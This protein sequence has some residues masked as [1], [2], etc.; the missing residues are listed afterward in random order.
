MPER[1]TNR[2]L[3][4]NLYPQSGLFYETMR[5]AGFS[6]QEVDTV[7]EWTG[8]SLNSESMKN[9]RNLPVDFYSFIHKSIPNSQTRIEVLVETFSTS[10]S[11]LMPARADRMHILLQDL[12]KKSKSEPK[13]KEY[14]ATACKVMVPKE[15]GRMFSNGGIRM[16]FQALRDDDI[17]K[18]FANSTN[19]LVDFIVLVR[20][21]EISLNYYEEMMDTIH[22]GK[23]KKEFLKG[24]NTSFFWKLEDHKMKSG[25]AGLLANESR[26]KFANEIIRQKPENWKEKLVLFPKTVRTFGLSIVDNKTLQKSVFEDYEK[27]IAKARK[28]RLEEVKEKAQELSPDKRS[29]IST[30]LI[31]NLDSQSLLKYKSELQKKIPSYEVLDSAEL[32]RIKRREDPRHPLNKLGIARTVGFEIEFM[33]DSITDEMESTGLFEAL[34]YAGFKPGGGGAE[35]YEISPGPFYDPL[36][37]TSVFE[38]Y[39][40]AGILRIDSYD[41]FT[42]HFNVS[43]LGSDLVPLIRG[44]YL[45]GA[46][47]YS[48]D[49]FKDSQVRIG[50]KNH[51]LGQYIECKSFSV[52]TRSGFIW[53]MKAASYLSWALCAYDRKH[54]EWGEVKV[55]KWTEELSNIWHEYVSTLGEGLNSV[56]M[57]GYLY[58][59]RHLE[60]ARN[61]REQLNLIYPTKDSRYKNIDNVGNDSPFIFAVSTA[62]KKWPN[63]A[64]F[65]TE[66]A[67]NAVSK[68]ESL[69]NKFEAEVTRD[70]KKIEETKNMRDRV[71][72]KSEFCRKYKS[73]SYESVRDVF[74]SA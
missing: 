29:E 61:V 8:A 74:K 51:D 15:Y 55:D 35:S 72:L 67:N 40:D 27:R 3:L 43:A 36:T 59:S 24:L 58:E 6:G 5:R 33:M 13:V 60:S 28:M 18:L 54:K 20:D 53:N 17:F 57:Y 68:I 46:A 48:A 41:K 21:E 19:R 32:N 69:A 50:I 38:E 26:A 4:R 2:N 37:A 71:S 11:H 64:V 42:Y 45:T 23:H 44:L 34:G 62:D 65:A 47:Y 9:I 30:L 14:M 63:L 52:V 56:G 12:Y 66:I 22:K 31:K 1:Q 7:F 73:S 16:Y 10:N 49:N 39:Y 70:I 25:L